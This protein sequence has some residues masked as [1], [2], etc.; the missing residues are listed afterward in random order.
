MFLLSYYCYDLIPFCRNSHWPLC[1][2]HNGVTR[3]MKTF[4]QKNVLCFRQLRSVALLYFEVKEWQLVKS[5]SAGEIFTEISWELSWRLTGQWTLHWQPPADMQLS[6]LSLYQS[7]GSTQGFLKQ[8]HHFTVATPPTRVLAE[9]S[10][11]W[12]YHLS[13]VWL[14]SE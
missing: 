7:F 12:F 6:P 9:F 5:L 8:L 11:G 1:S 4:N 3:F 14:C 2:G 10:A 13:Q